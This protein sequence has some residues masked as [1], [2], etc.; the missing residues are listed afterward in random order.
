[1]AKEIKW[2]AEVVF[3][4]MLWLKMCVAEQEVLAGVEYNL[5][6]GMKTMEIFDAFKQEMQFLLNQYFQAVSA[7]VAHIE[8]VVNQMI[9][10]DQSILERVD[11]TPIEE[12]L[13]SVMEKR[14]E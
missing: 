1:M 4:Q 8:E 3:S 6:E 5:P 2:N 7:D 13:D 10:L 14:G 9:K 12:M 11:T